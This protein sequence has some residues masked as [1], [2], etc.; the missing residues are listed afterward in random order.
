MASPTT[1]RAGSLWRHPDFL[2]L[3]AGESLSL[4]G[5]Q[6]TVLA[7]PIVAYLL[8]NASVAEMGVLGALARLPM[9]LF[10]VVGVWVDRMRRRPVLIWSDVVRAAML[11]TVPLLFVMD[12]LTLWWLYVV[13][14]VMGV[15]G[16][17]FEIAYRSYLPI[18]VA[19]EQLG[20]GN[21]KLQLSDSVSKAV[22]PSL[23][24]LLLA[25]RSA[26]LVIL[27]DVVSYVASALCLV[28]IR[29]KED[30]PPP[31]AAGTMIA[32][33]R[34][35]FGFVMK[36]PVIRPLAIASAVYSFFDIGILQTLYIPYVVGEVDVPAAV[37]GGVL[38]V[39]GIGAIAGA[40]LSVRLMKSFGPGPTMFWSTV[41]G[42]SALILV[43]LAGGP[44][45][46]ALGMLGVSQLLVGLTTQV[47]VVNNITTLQSAT[48]RELVGR[49]IATIW[50]MGLVPAPVGALVAGLLGEVFGMRPV[51]FA[52]A[53]IGALVPM[54]VLWWS[55]IPRMRELPTAPV[56]S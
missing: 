38:A 23:A 27:V 36:Q 53:V 39:G 44:M 46:L 24:G 55:P 11:A 17:L 16:V 21:S 4:I 15:A 19:P 30:P 43:P 6:V 12:M 3:W 13:V 47:F 37:T 2:K 35:G 8:L 56:A 1:D 28:S 48:P 26:P 45:W 31:E 40:W 20:D 49:V 32:A 7:M 29:K 33:I 41:I 25:A 5:S 18:L 42:N 52:A 22:G 14:L 51:V 9:V 50:A 54:A 10:F 34:A